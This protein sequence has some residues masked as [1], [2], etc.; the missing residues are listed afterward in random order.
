MSLINGANHPSNSHKLHFRGTSPSGTP[1]G[2]GANGPMGLAGWTAKNLL[3]SWHPKPGVES[4]FLNTSKTGAMSIVPL[5]SS[6]LV[7][8][9]ERA[10]KRDGWLELQERLTEEMAAAVVWLFGVGFLQNQFEKV[11]NRGKN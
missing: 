4:F 8:R 1:S 11:A 3:A 2:F 5:E 6:V 7:G 10:Y 9:S